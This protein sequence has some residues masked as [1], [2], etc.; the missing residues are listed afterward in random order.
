MTRPPDPDPQ[1]VAR[2]I[3]QFSNLSDVAY[4]E[5]LA[6]NIMEPDADET[7]AFRSPELVYRSRDAAAYLL[8]RV[9]TEFRQRP[10]ESRGSWG[11]RAA[12]YRDRVGLERRRLETIIA[13]MRAQRG[14]LTAPPNPRGRAMRRLAQRYP[15]EF[16]QMVREEQQADRDRAAREKEERKAARRESRARRTDR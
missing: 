9:N 4:A 6:D 16:L 15:E 10:G 2:L 1:Q 12:A 14:I 7:A 11:R 13:G 8:A 3:E 5:A